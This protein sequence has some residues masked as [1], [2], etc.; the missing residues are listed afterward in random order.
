MKDMIIEKLKRRKKS[1]D[2]DLLIDSIRDIEK[3]YGRLSRADRRLGLVDRVFKKYGMLVN[4]RFNN[5]QNE[6]TPLSGDPLRAGDVEY[7]KTTFAGFDHFIVYNCADFRI[8]NRFD[9]LDEVVGEFGLTYNKNAKHVTKLMGDGLV[10]ELISRSMD[11]TK[12]KRLIPYEIIGIKKDYPQEKKLL[13]ELVNKV[14]SPTYVHI[15]ET[16]AGMDDP[17]HLKTLLGGSL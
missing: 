8:G 1:G 3:E 17:E 16:D 7:K 4:F 15:N 11:R 13:H 14:Y 9:V 12:G 6:I 5:G 10:A 2:F